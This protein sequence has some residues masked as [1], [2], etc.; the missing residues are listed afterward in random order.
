MVKALYVSKTVK[1]PPEVSVEVNGLQVKVKGPRGEIVKDFS[2]AKGISITIRNGEVIV[3]A[4][5]ADRELK[6]LVGTVAAHIKNM[7]IGVTKGFRYKL[8]IVYSHFPITIVVDEKNRIVRIKNFLGERADRVA[9][10]YGNVSVRV[11][12][13]DVVVE[14]TDI[15]EVGLT[16]ASIERATKIRDLDRR[17][18][19]DG[20]YIYERGVAE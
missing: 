13:S 9:K 20:I 10:I 5:R 6:A 19:A 17:I 7:V 2:H 15:E 14:G 16:A 11:D 8:K 18:F 12:G 4:H 1:I 3:E